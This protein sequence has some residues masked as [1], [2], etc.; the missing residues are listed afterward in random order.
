MLTASLVSGLLLTSTAPTLR[1]EISSPKTSLSV[2]E[3][4]KVTVRATALQ[5][6]AVPGWVDTTGQPLLE[7]WIDYGQGYVRYVDDDGRMREGVEGARRS[8]NVGDR[9]VETLVLVNGPMDR[10]TVPFPNPGRFRLGVVVRSPEGVV[11]GE[12]N[13]IAFDVVVPQGGDAAVVQQIRSQ[14]WVLRGGLPAPSYA[15]LAAQYPT[16]PY[17]HWGQR[18]I[19]LEKSNRIHNGEYPDTG[20]QYA[21]IGRGHPLTPQLY[22]QLADELRGASTWGQFDEERLRL[23]AEDLERAGDSAE[24]RN[25]WREILERFSGSEAA[26]EAKSRIDSTPPSLALS[27]SPATL[28]PPDNKLVTVT[29]G[30]DVH[31]DTDPKPSVKLRSV[32]CDDACNPARDVVGAALSTDDRSFQLRATRKGGGAG[33]TYTITYSA[34]DAS[35]NQA[36]AVTNVVV[37]HDQGK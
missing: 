4:V 36:T 24:A 35:G 2:F 17:L 12:S 21:E 5:P 32:T 27:P 3:P 26:E 14:P 18:A 9:F 31:D 25:V 22:R 37:P 6:V 33:R 7:T 23:A 15:A 10:P 30:V 20:E 11:L 8:L 1:V 28:W 34:T 19:A 16:S 13:T 29:I